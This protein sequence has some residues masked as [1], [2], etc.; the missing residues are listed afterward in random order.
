M[1]KISNEVQP[2]IRTINPKLPDKLAIVIEK[3]LAKDVSKRYQRG[4]EVAADLRAC[5]V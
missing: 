3:L 1:F 4:S 5:L 2:D